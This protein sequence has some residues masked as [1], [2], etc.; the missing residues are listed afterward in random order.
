MTNGN[1]ENLVTSIVLLFEPESLRKV[2]F[3][4]RELEGLLRPRV[5]VGQTVDGRLVLT[6][7]ADQIEIFLGPERFDVR[8]LSGRNPGDKP[9]G[10]TMAQ[11]VEKFGGCPRA[12]GF[13]YEIAYH[14]P[15]GRAS[16]EFLV[17]KFIS[18]SDLVK[19]LAADG[20]AVTLYY[21]RGTKRCTLRLEPRW[22]D[23]RSDSVY[24][25]VNVHE[26][27]RAGEGSEAKPVDGTELNNSFAFEYI[28]LLEL[29]TSL[30]EK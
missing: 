13:N 27:L 1:Y 28:R 14:V 23:P 19:Q 2:S 30:F 8:D 16:G 25:N 26:D 22:G 21:P 24:V 7:I 17:H 4:P 29:L 10:G 6:S 11:L 18:A 15:Q 9:L 20:A 3:T 12:I 5:S